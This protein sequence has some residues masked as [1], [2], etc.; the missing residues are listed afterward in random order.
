M[1]FLLNPH[2]VYEK[3]HFTRA[4]VWNKRLRHWL[5]IGDFLIAA[6]ANTAKWTYTSV[7]LVVHH[8][9]VPCRDFVR[10]ETHFKLHKS[11]L[12]SNNCLVQCTTIFGKFFTFRTGLLP[13][14]RI[15][16]PE[17]KASNKRP[18]ASFGFHKYTFNIKSDS[19]KIMWT[20]SIWT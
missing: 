7:T 4:I 19:A 18:K 3:Y 11:I 20:K 6:V 5:I 8:N 13:A 17:W 10:P 9:F 2:S 1:S 14:C 15:N 16:L 12:V